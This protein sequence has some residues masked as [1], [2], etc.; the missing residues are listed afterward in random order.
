MGLGPCCDPSSIM[1][2]GCCC[3]SFLCIGIPCSCMLCSVAV[4]QMERN[5]PGTV[6]TVQSVLPSVGSLAKAALIAV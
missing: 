2:M 6:S 1:M 3:F 4:G 5:M